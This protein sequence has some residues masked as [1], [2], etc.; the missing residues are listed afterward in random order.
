MP[1][2]D[3]METQYWWNKKTLL[4]MKEGQFA[5]PDASI[6]KKI[7]KISFSK[8]Q[9]EGPGIRIKTD[10][11]VYAEFYHTP[12]NCSQL[13]MGV[14][15]S[16]IAKEQDFLAKNICVANNF[17]VVTASTDPNTAAYFIKLGWKDLGTTK[18][19]FSDKITYLLKDF[20]EFAKSTGYGGAT[21]VDIAQL[22]DK[23]E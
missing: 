14:L 17:R 22:I 1:S 12:R 23:K 21:V 10:N 18:G 15:D 8:P 13:T 6:E 9:W 2:I 3:Y 20:S 5:I 16:R 19:R 11:G 7:G 4:A